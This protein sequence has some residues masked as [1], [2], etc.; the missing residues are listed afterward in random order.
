MQHINGCIPFLVFGRLLD[1]YALPITDFSAVL[2]RSKVWSDQQL[3]AP[4]AGIKI[5]TAIV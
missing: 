5:V 2:F 3:R 4:W 1:F